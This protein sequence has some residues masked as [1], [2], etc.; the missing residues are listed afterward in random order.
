MG[1]D[2]L[3]RIGSCG[4]MVGPME[5]SGSALA[6]GRVVAG[7]RR[8]RS[9]P[10]DH[11]LALAVLSSA[12]A[13]AA[14]ASGFSGAKLPMAVFSVALALVAVGVRDGRALEVVFVVAAAI[15]AAPGPGLVIGAA[16]V[17]TYAVGSYRSRRDAAVAALTV[18]VAVVVERVAWGFAD[19]VVPPMLLAV[20][21]AAAVGLYVGVRRTSAAER[22]QHERAQE[23]LVAERTAAEER[24]RIARELHDVVAH[25]L[26]L[27]VVQSEVLS[28]RVEDDELATAAAAVAELGRAAMGELH[29]TLDLLRGGEEPAERAP[30]PSLAELERLVEQAREGGLVVELLLAGRPRP[31]PAGVEVSA[32]RIVQEALTN[33][34]R[35]AAASRVEVRLRY[36]TDALEVSVEDDGASGEGAS[37]SSGHGLRGMRER[38]VMLGGAL[39]FGPLDE[40][41]YRVSAILPYADPS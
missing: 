31:L 4:R 30:Q 20:A 26:S 9:A 8:Y 15:V 16:L 27:I 11:G 14:E 12:V 29:R 18:V 3:R 25:T 23:T 1:F 35:H 7:L 38:A 2:R 34:R 5:E 37:E 36:G 13:F 33:V 10:L 39:S 17:A 19:D 24:V 32:F 21:A 22:V 41:G 40:G 28:R 6:S